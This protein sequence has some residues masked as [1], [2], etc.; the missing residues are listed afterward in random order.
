MQYYKYH[1]F[2]CVNQRTDGR[3]CCQDRNAASMRDYM[4]KRVKQENLAG[5][6]AVRVNPQFHVD[7]SEVQV[8]ADRSLAQLPAS[9]QNLNLWVPV[10]DLVDGN[11]GIVE[12][13]DLLKRPAEQEEF[14]GQCGF[15]G[16]GMAD[17]TK[18][19]SAV[20]FI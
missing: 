16:I 15:T 20:N 6:G 19:P 12:F 8:S 10:G 2:F 3:P 9:L 17:N 14:L 4:K 1:I 11:I 7:A 18:G 13:S 5:S